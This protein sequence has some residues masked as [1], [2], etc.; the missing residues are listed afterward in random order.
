[1][2]SRCFGWL[3][4]AKKVLRS[5]LDN[6]LAALPRL[7]IVSQQAIGVRLLKFASR[8]GLG[9]PLTKM[10][11]PD[12]VSDIGLRYLVIPIMAVAISVA[13]SPSDADS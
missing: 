3:A 5:S 4:T 9:K 13:S 6:D 10:S 2:V 8:L 7:K 1:M 11:L 12:Y